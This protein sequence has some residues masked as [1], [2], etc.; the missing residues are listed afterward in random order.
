MFDYILATYQTIQPDIVH[1]SD[2]SGMSPFYVA[3]ALGI[4]ALFHVRVPGA[5][6]LRDALD[7]ADHILAVS[8]HVRGD[9]MR[10][11][12]DAADVTTVHSGVDT[13]RYAPGNDE[14]RRAGRRTFDLAD[15]DRLIVMVGRFHPVKRHDV[16]IHAIRDLLERHRNVRGLIVGESDFAMNS[17]SYVKGLLAKLDLAKTIRL[18]GFQSDMGPI[19]AAAD[20]AVLCSDAEPLGL[21]AL[22]AMASKTPTVISTNGGLPPLVA[23]TNAAIVVPP[24]N[25]LALASAIESI[26]LDPE[27]AAR[28]RQHG[29]DFVI[30]RFDSRKTHG[31]VT[32][33]YDKIIERNQ[34]RQYSA[35]YVG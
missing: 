18:A 8:E 3:S 34:N 27:L 26:L 25:S 1:V 7:A 33:V 29:R 35:G 31:A 11:G 28:L 32:S 10:N 24:A 22:E 21:S 9:V 30:S 15:D 17:L 4:P 2:F 19:Y 13:V 5:H 20:V 12:V 14:A 6:L 23:G 16:F